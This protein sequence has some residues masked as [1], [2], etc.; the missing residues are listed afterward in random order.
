M[1]G[2]GEKVT[3]CYPRRKASEETDP[4]NTLTLD[5]NLHIYEE[6]KSVV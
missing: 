2:H 3:I 1:R 5:Y 6:I 4:A